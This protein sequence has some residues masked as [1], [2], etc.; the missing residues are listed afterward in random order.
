MDLESFKKVCQEVT[1]H[2]P[3]LLYDLSVTTLDKTNSRLSKK[4]QPGPEWDKD[5]SEMKEEVNSVIV[6]RMFSYVAADYFYS[7]EIIPRLIEY[8]KDKYKSEGI[9][10]AWDD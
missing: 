6:W 1:D 8:L 5:F 4:Y 10:F 3:K 9:W 7:S 2:Y